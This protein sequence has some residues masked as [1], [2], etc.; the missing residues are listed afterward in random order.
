M[1]AIKTTLFPAIDDCLQSGTI[2]QKSKLL[3]FAVLVVI[4]FAAHSASLPL[5]AQDTPKSETAAANG[6]SAAQPQPASAAPKETSADNSAAPSGKLPS[7]R[8]KRKAVKLYLHATKLYTDS[9]FEEAQALYLKAAA[10]DPTNPNY[11]VAAEL[12]RSY[13]VTALVQ[14]AA[15]SRTRGDQSTARE[16]LARALNLDPQNPIVTQHIGELATDATSGEVPGLYL[17]AANQ[18]GPNVVLEPSKEKHS[19]HLHT[20]MRQIIQQVFAAYGIQ[21]IIDDSVRSQIARFDVD[22]VDFADATKL[23]GIITVSFYAPIDAHRAIIARDNTDLRG[24]YLRTELETIYP[25]G[26]SDKERTDVETMAKSIFDLPQAKLNASSGTLTIRALPQ[27]LD[28]FNMTLRQLL[29]GRSQMVLDVRMIQLAN[30]QARNTGATIPQQFSVFN[31]GIEEA[32]LLNNNQALVQQIISSGLASANNPLAILAI[33]YASGQVTD[34]ILQS[35]ISS[36]TGIF[37]G[38]AST[39]GITPMQTTVNLNINSSDSRELDGIQLRLGDDEKGTIKTG[40]R[41]PITTSTFS[42]SLGTT[43]SIPGLTGAGS[44]SSLYSQYTSSLNSISAPMIEYQDIGLTLNATPRILREG[45]IALTLDLKLTALSGGS[46]NGVPILNSRAYAGVV[47]LKEGEGVVLAS[48]IDKQESRALSGQPGI[49][50]I[51]GLNNITSVVNSTNYASL[52]IVLTPHLVRGTQVGGHSPI[53][54]IDRRKIG[55]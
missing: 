9:K 41:Y 31:V 50:D 33:L 51:P 19:F 43:P 15:A 14:S 10:L 5:R 46:V 32:A 4:T 24:Q 36:G 54:L 27:T 53:M 16:S 2:Q 29:E 17:D 45:E 47:T 44:S 48:E 23:L 55:P 52:L 30:L 20:N 11:P 38:G 42:S 7:S 18:I 13:A 26:L 8:D 3:S 6:Q 37:G 1:K 35:I 28:A 22:N 39:T 25:P 40:V 12:A 49:T 21:V 34:P